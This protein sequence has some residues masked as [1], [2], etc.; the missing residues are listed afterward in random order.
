MIH[1]WVGVFFVYGVTQT[2]AVVIKPVVASAPKVGFSG[3]GQLLGW[4]MLVTCR[5]FT[6]GFYIAPRSSSCFI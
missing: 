1:R 2:A 3:V 5:A 4:P 6:H